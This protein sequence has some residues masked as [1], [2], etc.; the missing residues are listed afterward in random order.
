MRI[1]RAKAGLPTPGS[2]GLFWLGQAGFWLETGHHRILIDPYLSDSL[3]TKYKGRQY[4]HV[5]MMPPPV[6]VQDLPR[7][8][9]VLITH[10]HTDHLDPETL[11][12]LH[13]RFSDL[14]FVVPAS[15]QELALERIGADARLILVDADQ[16]LEPLPD[17]YLRTFPA[18]HETLEKDLNGH[19]KFLGYGIK[20]R[21]LRVYH[22]GDCIPFTGLKERV[23]AFDP[24]ICLLPVNG[25]D[26]LRKSSG[27]PGNFTLEEAIHL[28]RHSPFLIPHH[29]DMFAFNT[30]DPDKIDDATSRMTTPHII[31]PLAEECLSIHV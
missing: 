24:Q 10:A 17:L 25:R 5:R 27:I 16:T 6:E 26:E 28:A 18:A 13:Q 4:D 31:R 7:P 23:T 11:A 1:E 21:N 20:T 2:P 12:P 22:S 29:Y 3:A 8:D 19:H 30:I 14:D 9:L 15:S